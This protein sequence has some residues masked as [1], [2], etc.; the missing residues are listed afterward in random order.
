VGAVN[1]PG[2]FVPQTDR[3]RM[4]NLKKLSLAGGPVNTAKIKQC[5]ILRKNPDTGKRDEVPVDLDKVM[6]LKSED[7]TLQASDILFVP[8][9]AGK[10]AL[11]RAGDVALSLTTGV[12]LV[13]AGRL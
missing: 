7:V 2:G 11:H 6:H 4:T 13:S 10:R 5:V 8:D 12:A 9:S 3:H 1:P